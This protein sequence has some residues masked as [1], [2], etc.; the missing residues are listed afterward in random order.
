M[1]VQVYL[2]KIDFPKIAELQNT[3]NLPGIGEKISLNIDNNQERNEFE[4]TDV[5]KDAS[6]IYIYVNP[7][8]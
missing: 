7:V 1:T 5:K 8:H 3:D 4:V 6:K 2:N